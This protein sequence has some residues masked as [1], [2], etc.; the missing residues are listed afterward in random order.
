MTLVIT[1][2][3]KQAARYT[4]AGGRER[5]SA[6][7]FFMP[8]GTCGRIIGPVS[9]RGWC[10]FYSQEAV[11]RWQPQGAQGQGGSPTL[12]LSFISGS[13]TLD[14]RITFTRASTATYFDSSGVMRTAASGAPRF[15]Y[16]SVTHAVRGLLIEEARTNIA[17]NSGNASVWGFSSAVTRTA[18]AGVAPDGTNTATLVADT[19]ANSQHVCGPTT[20]TVTANTSYA[21]SAYIKP[22]GRPRV[23][24]TLINSGFSSGI[25]ATLNVTTGAVV[26]GPLYIGTAS[27]GFCSIT[28]AGN[29][30]YRCVVGGIVDAASTAAIGAIY[31]DNGTSNSYAGDGVS[32]ALV[33]GGQIEL[34]AFAT[35]YIPTTAAAVTRA[36][37]ACSMPVAAWYNTTTGSLSHEYLLEGAPPG[38]SAP[39]ALVGVSADTDFIDLDEYA[40]G[41]ATAPILHVVAMVMTGNATRS[42]LFAAAP[43]VPAGSAHRGAVAWLLNNVVR[44]AHDGTLTIVDGSGAATA[45]PT[46]VNLTIGGPKGYQPMVSQ[47]ARRVR[48]WPRALSDAELQQVT[49]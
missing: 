9:P 32:G 36:A 11:Q 30:W 23:N 1:R 22:A 27:A 39:A 34:G 18:S 14:P 21:F 8:Q 49:T 45:I 7:R 26:T 37:D 16:D 42:A 43:T 13:G 15:D 3:T 33:W 4:D 12:D 5:C 47:W 28:P 2:A 6:C 38:Y 44:G 29:G 25:N 10:R 17:L 19:V 31:L 24:I 20:V 46:I 41:A 40:Q 48:Y 35:S